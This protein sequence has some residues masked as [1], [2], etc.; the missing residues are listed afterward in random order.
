MRSPELED[1]CSVLSRSELIPAPPSTSKHEGPRPAKPMRFQANIDSF[2]QPTPGQHGESPTCATLGSHPSEACG[3]NA[4]VRNPGSLALSSLSVPFERSKRPGPGPA[5]RIEM[6]KVGR[7]ALVAALVTH[8]LP[9]GVRTTYLS[10]L[11]RVT[12]PTHFAIPCLNVHT[13]YHKYNILSQFATFCHIF[14]GKLIMGECGTSVMTPFVLTPSG[15]C[16]VTFSQP[17]TAMY[18]APFFQTY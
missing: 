16:Q 10:L 6:R 3:L 5:S 8:W 9:D 17:Q 12:N 14:Q 1:D 4:V 11:R 13:F 15:S 2:S 7:P 18:A